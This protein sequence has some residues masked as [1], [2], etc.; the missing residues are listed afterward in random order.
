MG[1]GALECIDPRLDGK[2]KKKTTVTSE[3]SLMRLNVWDTL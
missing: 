2:N 3:K 1:R